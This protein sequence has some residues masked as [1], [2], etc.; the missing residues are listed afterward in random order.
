LHR[1]PLELLPRCIVVRI[2]CSIAGYQ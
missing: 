1:L 2:R